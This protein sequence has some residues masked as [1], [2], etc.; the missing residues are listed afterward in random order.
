MSNLTFYERQ[1]IEFYLRLKLGAREIARRIGRNHA[2]ILREIKRNKNPGAKYYSAKLAQEKAEKRSHKTN[3]RK[4]DKDFLLELY[5]REKLK[6]GWSPEQIAGRLKRNPP[7]YLKGQTICYES[8]YQYIY[9]SPYGRYLYHYLRYKR[10]PRRQKHYVRKSQKASILERIFIDE[11]PETINQRLRLGDWESDTMQFRK[12]RASVSA[13]YERK[14]SLVRLH[15]V[16]DR[17][18]EETK[19]ALTAT[20]E[21]LPENSLFQ[22]ITFDNGG[23]NACHIALKDIYGIDTYFCQPYKSW[24]KGGVEN[25]IG[26][27]RQ[28]LPRSCSLDT[29]DEKTLHEIQESLNNRPRKKLG[30]LTPN[31]VIHQHLSWPGGGALNP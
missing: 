1:K 7:S 10:A 3:K 12:Q 13:Q 30:Y 29:I 19:R 8:I 5:V 25:C 11:R 17:S 4:L 9:E 28:Y 23:E 21:S 14:S 22:S 26:L 6:K 18:A 31:E 27:V 20:A 16:K 24:Q 2:V 15:K